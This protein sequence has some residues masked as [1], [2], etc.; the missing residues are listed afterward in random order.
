MSKD[1]DLAPQFDEQELNDFL[2]MMGGRPDLEVRPLEVA[3]IDPAEVLLTKWKPYTLPQLV[4]AKLEDFPE[5]LE[6][7]F[8]FE[9]FSKL[10]MVF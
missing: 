5:K 8:T 9:W 1:M 3:I 4:P 10:D 6:V 7:G 2:D